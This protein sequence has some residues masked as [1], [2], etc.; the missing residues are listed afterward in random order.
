MKYLVDVNAFSEPTKPSPD[1]P[2]V[3][4]L[5][6]HEPDIAVD[7]GDSRRIALGILILSKGKKR[8]ALERCKAS[9]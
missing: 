5:R 6:A 8:V 4:W 9:R 1:P 2:V 7:P 3:D